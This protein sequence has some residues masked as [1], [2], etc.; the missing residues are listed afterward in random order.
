MA[1]QAVIYEGDAPSKNERGFRLGEQRK[2]VIYG[3]RG[4]RTP[5]R[6][7]TV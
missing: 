2:W 5:I 3:E 4:I 1:Y 7:L 6:L